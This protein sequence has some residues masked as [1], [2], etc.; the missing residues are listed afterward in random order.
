MKPEILQ[1]LRQGKSITLYKPYMN[2]G[3]CFFKIQL[4]K[5]TSFVCWQMFVSK[6][7]QNWIKLNECLSLKDINSIFSKN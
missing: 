6:D 2:C 1:K 3:K 4:N 5:T 7:K